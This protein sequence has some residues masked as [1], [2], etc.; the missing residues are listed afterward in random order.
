MGDRIPV[1]FADQSLPAC[2]RSGYRDLPGLGPVVERPIDARIDRSPAELTW[3]VDTSKVLGRYGHYS[4][5][6]HE[7]RIIDSLQTQLRPEHREH[8]LQI[9]K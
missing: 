2:L 3:D 9:A 5:W 8:P 6:P 7:R 1:E 4:P